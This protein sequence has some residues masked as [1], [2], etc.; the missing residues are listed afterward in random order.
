MVLQPLA[1]FFLPKYANRKYWNLD[2]IINFLNCFAVILLVRQQELHQSLTLNV[3]LQR[4]KRDHI[5]PLL[6][7]M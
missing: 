5:A 3:V 7:V 6:L 2:C 1:M 4:I